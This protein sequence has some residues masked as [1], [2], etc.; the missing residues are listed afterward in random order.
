MLVR[1]GFAVHSGIIVR[2]VGTGSQLWQPEG[3]C[4]VKKLRCCFLKKR[5]FIQAFF[6]L[7]YINN[8]FAVN[9]LWNK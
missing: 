1:D 4:Q 8:F 6:M 3:F 2:E 5:I 9:I 7:G